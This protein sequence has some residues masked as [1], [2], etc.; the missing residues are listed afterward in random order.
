MTRP[1][2]AGRSSTARRWIAS[3]TRSLLSSVM[4]SG[5]QSQTSATQIESEASLPV[6]GN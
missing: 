4:R 5:S 1:L 3:L 6:A 2:V